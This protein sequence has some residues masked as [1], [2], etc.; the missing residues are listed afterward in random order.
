[1]YQFFVGGVETDMIVLLSGK[2][3]SPT[4]NESSRQLSLSVETESFG[5]PVGFAPEEDEFTGFNNDVAG[6]PWPMCFGTV[7]K[8]PCVKVKKFGTSARITYD[9]NSWGEYALVG[10]PTAN[11]GDF[12]F[13][14]D[15]SIDVEIG[16]VK[17][18]GQFTE[19]S[20]VVGNTTV[21]LPIFKPSTVNNVHDT[22]ILLAER[23]EY[24]ADYSSMSVCWLHEDE[25]VVLP[26]K[27]C[28]IDG[29]SYGW[30]VN[31]CIRQQGTKCYFRQPW[32][33][34]LEGGTIEETAPIVRDSWAATYSAGVNDLDSRTYSLPSRWQVKEYR[35]GANVLQDNFTVRSGAS[36]IYENGNGAD[37]YVANLLP[38]SE[39]LEVFAYRTYGSERIFVPVPSSRYTKYL[40]YSLAG[41]SV[42]AFE[43]TIPLATYER[44]MWE[45]GLFVSMRSY[46]GPN[47]CSIIKYLL[48][49][50]T[51]LDVNETNYQS[52][53]GLINDYLACFMV[54]GQPDAIQ[55]IEDIAYQSRL[56]LVN[57]NGIVYFTSLPVEPTTAETI[58]DDLVLLDS[59]T[60][61][62]TS[63]DD[64]I[65]NLTGV[66][67]EDYS[68]REDIEHEYVY[69][70]NEATH[71][72]H[73]DDMVVSIYNVGFFAKT[74]VDFWGSRRSEI[75]RTLQYSSFMNDLVVQL[76]DGVDH[77]ITILSSN[78]IKGIAQNIENNSD[79]DIITV[80]YELASKAGDVDGSDK[81]QETSS[82]WP[83]NPTVPDGL[84]PG[85]GRQEIDY[86]P[87]VKDDPD[88]GD[89]DEPPVGDKYEMHIDIQ[90]S[91]VVRG[92][93]FRLQI[94]IHDGDG[95]LYQ[96]GQSVFM[97]LTSGDSGDN[98][99]TTRSN[100]T[101][102]VMGIT[103]MQIT[104]GT[105][106]TTGHIT[107]STA[108]CPDKLTATFPI[109][110]AGTPGMAWTVPVDLVRSVAEAFS[111][112]GGPASG[113]VNVSLDSTDN[114]DDIYLDSDNSVVTQIALDGAGEWAADCYVKGGSG[115][116]K[117]TVL[118]EDDAGVYAPAYS[119]DI[120]ISGATLE[121]TITQDVKFAQSIR[122]TLY[123]VEISLPDF[124]LYSAFEMDVTVYDE[125][126]VLV[127]F[128]G[129]IIIYVINND[130]DQVPITVIGPDGTIVGGN[131]TVA[132]A[133]GNW[134]Y[135]GVEIDWSEA[136]MEMTF[137]A[138][139]FYDGIII[140]GSNLQ[141]V[142]TAKFEVMLP[143]TVSDYNTNF[144]MTV[145][146]Y[147][148]DGTIN[149][150]YTPINP[151]DIAIDGG[152]GLQT[153]EIPIASFVDGVATHT[154]QINTATD[155]P[156]EFTITV[157]DL[158]N[159]LTGS[160]K[161]TVPDATTT[162][163]TFNGQGTGFYLTDGNTPSY[164]YDAG[165]TPP[166]DPNDTDAIAY[167]NW[168]TVRNASLSGILFNRVSCLYDLKD[169]YGY[170]AMNV[171]R[172]C[173]AFSV[174]IPAGYT[175]EIASAYL[176]ISG[177]VLEGL[178]IGG[179][180]GTLQ[181]NSSNFASL[182]VKFSE[183]ATEIAAASDWFT[184]DYD[185]L[186]PGSAITSG[187][188]HNHASWADYNYWQYQTTIDY[189]I[190][191]D[192]TIIQGMA[193]NTLYI[194]MWFREAHMSYKGLSYTNGKTGPFG[195]Y[196]GRGVSAGAKPLALIL[197]K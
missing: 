144:S 151:V 57:D 121:Q 79:D 82:Y 137:W 90:P 101:S 99:N 132:A 120:A 194:Y 173:A 179:W 163:T 100:F 43:F 104:G 3:M 76:Y 27:Y 196:T 41:H 118:G 92:E 147:S 106:N 88:G 158:D 4:W 15:S 69:S 40:N 155:K 113:D 97:A 162:V 189:Y 67:K 31:Y 140:T 94:S 51:D 34:L 178:N 127:D 167:T 190:P 192:P 197:N 32:D 136:G 65:T 129:P 157:T 49:T 26:G 134:N 8:V 169:Q 77:D 63:I 2:L 146:C 5:D 70:N 85:I 109:R 195:N 89:G 81:P 83:G 171:A 7:L 154:N 184:I 123:W 48:E 73:K 59:L 61:G 33:Y 37:L 14:V 71:G 24:D 139:A 102:G 117:A 75:W 175:A 84:D 133:L 38:S 58:N 149:T 91:E 131:G 16:G 60:L 128:N 93:N 125:S 29:G 161:T 30:M 159:I 98:I 191:I 186:I 21:L 170:P 108:L 124:E 119:N 143:A 187:Y 135:A 52:V 42:T 172:Y 95:Q 44:E 55:L 54:D 18:T 68:S 17:C 183:S 53:A 86:I 174:T 152:A 166:Y 148:D 164:V 12:L 116:D 141:T 19:E 74:S 107:F 56:A 110:D 168:N 111:L 103:T 114:S 50:Y 87:P 78:T 10:Y 9:W 115:L 153:Y 150:A 105:G 80:S 180:G 181:V 47:S 145:T 36:F 188:A 182:A 28:I 122:E 142:G 35:S 185:N 25:N 126:G 160:A 112:T 64:I 6:V 13:P 62:F 96:T 23:T 22:N 45:D 72:E 66:W 130:G 20:V 193:G 46:I 177:A 11:N 156:Y 138:E 1:V 39:V 176:G 165:R